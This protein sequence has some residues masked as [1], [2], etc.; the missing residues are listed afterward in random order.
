MA[1]GTFTG[2]DEGKDYGFIV[3]NDGGSVVIVHEE[4]FGGQQNVKPGAAVKYSSIQGTPGPKAYNVTVL[5]LDKP[6]LGLGANRSRKCKKRKASRRRYADEI[7]SVLISKV[8]DITVAE[9]VEV[10]KLLVKRAA[11]R[12]WLEVSPGD[13]ANAE[14]TTDI[15]EGS[16]G[17]DDL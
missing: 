2:F 17:N 5:D 4:S 10:R 6:R 15:W 8:S 7:T 14:D 16:R 11:R 9:I 13:N 12:G 3:P 1:I